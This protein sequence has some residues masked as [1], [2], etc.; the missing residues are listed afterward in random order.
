MSRS[1]TEQNKGIQM[2]LSLSD[3]SEVLLASHRSNFSNY[4]DGFQ[5]N[6]LHII[7]TDSKYLNDKCSKSTGFVRFRRWGSVLN[8][9]RDIKNAKFEACD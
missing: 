7:H 9:V 4:G 6:C 2:L 5:L 8:A 3:L 1:G